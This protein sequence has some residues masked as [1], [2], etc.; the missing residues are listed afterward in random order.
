MG[1]RSGASRAVRLAAAGAIGLGFVGGPSAAEPPPEDTW[2]LAVVPYLWALALQGETEVAGTTAEIDRGIL[3]NLNDFE[4]GGMVFVD[5][6]YRRFVATVDGFSTRISDNRGGALLR[7]D[8][9]STTL[10]GDLKAG[11][12]LLDTTVP[13][14]DASALDSPRILL[15]LL[16]GVR[17][18][19]VRTE[20]ETN[21]LTAQQFDTWKDWVDPL[22]GAR[23]GVGITG[24]LNVSVLGDVGGFD[25]G[26]ASELTWMVMPTLN[27]KPSEHWSFHVGYKHLKA[28]RE[29]PSTNNELDFELTGPVLGFGYHF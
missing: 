17:Y 6:R 8:A 24:T 29:R 4:L 3:D 25:M 7:V 21:G 12:R 1:A 26:N 18:W 15:D 11:F 28:E 13:W 14:A 22:V 20:L 19:A 10:I 16:G 27:W 23:V 5:A 2:D 9:T